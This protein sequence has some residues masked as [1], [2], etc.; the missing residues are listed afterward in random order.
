MTMS[1]YSRRGAI[2]LNYGANGRIK[3]GRFS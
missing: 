1:D 2:K 3:T